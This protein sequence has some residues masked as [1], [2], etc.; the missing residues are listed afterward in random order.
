[1]E[2]HTQT[3]APMANGQAGPVQRGKPAGGRGGQKP[4]NSIGKDGRPEWPQQ[5]SAPFDGAEGQQQQQQPAAAGGYHRNAN[6]SIA[7][8]HANGYPQQKQEQSLGQL[9]SSS[10]EKRKQA[11]ASECAR[12]QAVRNV[13]QRLIAHSRDN[14]QR[15]CTWRVRFALK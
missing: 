10:L 9:P 15:T 4:R 3:Q 12:L 14:A 7:A 2:G 6:G 5:H 8:V 13:L 11:L 1:M